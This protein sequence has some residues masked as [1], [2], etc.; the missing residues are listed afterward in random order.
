MDKAQKSVIQATCKQVI[1]ALERNNMT[2]Y[3]VDTAAEVVDK[4]KQLIPEGATIAVGGSMTLEQTGV[5]KLIRSG[6]YEFLDR[7]APGLTP[8]QAREIFLKSFA[9]DVYLSSVNAI[10]L[11][12]ELYNV[13]GRSNRVASI[14]FGPASVIL[15]VGCNKIVKDIDEA[16]VRVKRV[17]APANAARLHCG[18]PCTEAGFC[19][20]IRGG[21][22]AGCANDQ[23]ICSTYMVSGWQREKGRIKVILVG[24]PVGY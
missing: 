19:A 1:T 9:A 23:R 11:N 18:T 20:G 10:T 21:M 24:E 22:T 6:S 2:G 8:E 12:G 4:V 13:D 15:V 3:Y 5:M 17:A 14:A 16:I 7:Y